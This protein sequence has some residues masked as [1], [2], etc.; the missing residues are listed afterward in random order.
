[1]NLLLTSFW[2]F[3]LFTNIIKD[4]M[5]MVLYYIL[6]GGVVTRRKIENEKF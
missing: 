1:M 2:R 3:G 4:D 6:A 5:I